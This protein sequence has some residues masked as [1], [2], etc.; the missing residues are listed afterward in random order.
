MVKDPSNLPETQEMIKMI[1]H[2]GERLESKFRIT[3]QIILNLF[4]S[5]DMNV[6]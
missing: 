2:P 6:E 1:D 3:Y 5:K 4:N